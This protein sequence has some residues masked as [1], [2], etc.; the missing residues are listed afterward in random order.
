MQIP[1]VHPLRCSI[2]PECG[3]YSTSADLDLGTVIPTG[4]IVDVH[5][6]LVD[7]IPTLAVRNQSMQTW[8]P[9]AARTRTTARLKK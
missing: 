4:A 6:K 8:T 2:S 9:I 1:P 5:F 7:S 3:S